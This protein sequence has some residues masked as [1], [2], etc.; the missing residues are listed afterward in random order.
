MED[1]LCAMPADKGGMPIRVN[2]PAG[3]ISN[4]RWMQRGGDQAA[5]FPKALI[6]KQ[7]LNQ[8]AN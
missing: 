8:N 5:N 6:V 1:R 4:K 7:P 3:G 2:Q